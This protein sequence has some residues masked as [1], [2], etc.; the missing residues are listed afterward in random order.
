MINVFESITPDQTDEEAKKP[1]LPSG[2]RTRIECQEH[3]RCG[4]AQKSG[5]CVLSLLVTSM[6]DCDLRQFRGCQ[7]RRV[8]LSNYYK[9]EFRLSSVLLSPL[10][11]AKRQG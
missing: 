9:A 8:L 3:R 1:K 5:N 2:S 11:L 4:S 10:T 7:H 6:P